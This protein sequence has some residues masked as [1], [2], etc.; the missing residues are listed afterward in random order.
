MELH[1]TS[2]HHV[3]LMNQAGR[4][5]EEPQI[6]DPKG[7]VGERGVKKPKFVDTAASLLGSLAYSWRRR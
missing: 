1:V 6:F 2:R 5:S 7:R 4:S 3:E